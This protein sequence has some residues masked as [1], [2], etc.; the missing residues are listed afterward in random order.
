[1]S[2][3][4]REQTPESGFNSLHKIDRHHPQSTAVQTNALCSDYAKVKKYAFN[5]ICLVN[6]G[7]INISTP[8]CLFF[9]PLNFLILKILFYFILFY[10]LPHISIEKTTSNCNFSRTKAK[11]Y[12][13][14]KGQ[15]PT[16]E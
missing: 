5:P 10:F 11:Y 6:N 1:M 13:A 4:Y 3:G 8:S 9:L 15:Y 7:F 12:K 2:G 16:I 14:V